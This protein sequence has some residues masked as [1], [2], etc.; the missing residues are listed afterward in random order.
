MA[1]VATHN[2]EASC[3]SAIR[4]KVYDLT[5]WIGQ[6]PGGAQNIKKLCGTDGT[7]FFVGQHAGSPPQENRLAG[8]EIGTVK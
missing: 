1:E 8:F 5:S 4:G 7:D 2:S 6:H 3:W